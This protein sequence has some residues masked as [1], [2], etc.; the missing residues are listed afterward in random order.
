MGE[1]LLFE[2]STERQAEKR[3]RTAVAFYKERIQNIIGTI[4]KM[5]VERMDELKRDIENDNDWLDI[6]P[7]VNTLIMRSI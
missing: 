1:S 6:V 3:K 4:I 2:K 7:F 5:T